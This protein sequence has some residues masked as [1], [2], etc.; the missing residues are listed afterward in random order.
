M[1]GST[2]ELVADQIVR[3]DRLGPL[4]RLVFALSNPPDDGMHPVPPDDVVFIVVPTET[5][6]EIRNALLSAGP[7]LKA[8]RRADGAVELVP[9]GRDVGPCRGR[10]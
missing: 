10:C 5:I 1:S 7:I 8:S 6:P 9:G 3:I 4:T 2:L